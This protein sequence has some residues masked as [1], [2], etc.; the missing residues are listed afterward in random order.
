MW[1]RDPSLMGK[2][3]HYGILCLTDSIPNWEV[4]HWCYSF[5]AVSGH[6]KLCIRDRDLCWQCSELGSV[7]Q[8]GV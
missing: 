8:H 3:I 4:Q 6:R 5:L 1:G 2:A 7:V